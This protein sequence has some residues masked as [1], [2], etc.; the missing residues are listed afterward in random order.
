M[1]DS[2]AAVYRTPVI[3]LDGA[4]HAQF[5]SGPRPT[6]IKQED[7]RPDLDMTEDYAHSMIGRHVNNFIMTNLINSS[8]SSMMDSSF[9]EMVEAYYRSS[10]KFQP[11]LDVRNFGANSTVSLWTVEAQK[12]FAGQFSDF[13]EIHNKVEDGLG[14]F[15]AGPSIE[16]HNNRITAK[17]V[18][19]VQLRDNELDLDTEE[20]SPVEVN[21]KLNSEDAI[22]R[23]VVDV[24]KLDK[25]QPNRPFAS[26]RG[27]PTTC[28]SLNE[29]AL[30]I[31]L[32]NSS[33]K[34]RDR[35]KA[36]GRPIIFERDSVCNFEFMWHMTPL[37]SWEEE[38]GLHVQSVSY[39]TSSDFAQDGVNYCKVI[40]PYR[41]MEWV[42]VDSLRDY[43]DWI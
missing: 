26:N 16:V 25:Y 14:F 5:A 2:F 15:L 18:T 28:R 34:S 6:R 11:L 39:S 9:D 3:L 37:Q 17:T 13:I 42:N 30:E 36:R 32:L 33:P 40:S 38:D 10:D 8:S 23:T 29:L 27:A 35:Y 31:A 7:L 12:H 19:F 21:M 22:R 4:N 20:E 24:S 1:S 41:A 43:P